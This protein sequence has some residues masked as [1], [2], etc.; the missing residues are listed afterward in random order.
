M[1]RVEGERGGYVVNHIADGYRVVVHILLRS[2]VVEL[3]AG[4][5]YSAAPE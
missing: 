1:L 2:R 4:R 3:A 5:S